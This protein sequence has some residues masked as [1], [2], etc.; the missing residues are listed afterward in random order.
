MTIFVEVTERLVSLIV[1]A[2]KP[3]ILEQW[4]TEH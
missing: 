4:L 3:V 1:D 2:S